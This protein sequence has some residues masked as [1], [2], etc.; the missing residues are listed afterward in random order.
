VRLTSGQVKQLPSLKVLGLA[1]DGKRYTTFQALHDDL[2]FW[3][4]APRFL[5]LLGRSAE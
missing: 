1:E 5:C 4:Y 3:P 2:A